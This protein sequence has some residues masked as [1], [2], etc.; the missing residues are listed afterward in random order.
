M[1]RPM[2]LNYRDDLLN[3]SRRG[4]IIGAKEIKPFAQGHEIRLRG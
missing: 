2:L 4:L 1:V 3:S